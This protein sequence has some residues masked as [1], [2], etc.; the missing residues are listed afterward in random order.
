MLGAEVLRPNRMP[1]ALEQGCEC[2]EWRLL[3][4]GHEFG[5][6]GGGSAG[7]VDGTTDVGEVHV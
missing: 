6:C 3:Q 4:Q 7:R 1:Q 2:R 5:G